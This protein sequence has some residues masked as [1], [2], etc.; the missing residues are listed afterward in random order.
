MFII[1]SI[2]LIAL[3]IVSDNELS[4]KYYVPLKVACSAFFVAIGLIEGCGLSVMLPVGLCALGDL[5]MALYN[6]KGRKRFLLTG[7]ILFFGAHVGFLVDFY[8]IQ[9]ELDIVAIIA[10][11]GLCAL[12]AVLYKIAHF[13]MGKMKLPGLLYCFMVSS[14]CVKSLLIAWGNPFVEVQLLALGG[15]LFFLSDFSILFLYFYHFKKRRTKKLV[16]SFN[17]ITYYVAIYLFLIILH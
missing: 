6:Q 4:K 7:I 14:M 13:H 2:L 10:P 3:L 9:P 1:Y 12:F 15:V 16:H 17:L 5:F 8:R 11:V